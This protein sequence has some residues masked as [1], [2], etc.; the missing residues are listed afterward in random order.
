MNHMPLALREPL[1][2]FMSSESSHDLAA[3]ADCFAAHAT[4]RGEG[5]TMNG[6]NAIKTWRL[7]TG[8]RYQHTVEPVAVT[9]RDG[10]TALE[11]QS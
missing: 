4:V 7:E 5:Q 3:L 2:L 1:E 6:L 10:R 8:Q 9:A 11:I